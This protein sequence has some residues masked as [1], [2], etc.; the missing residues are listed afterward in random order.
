M[1]DQAPTKPLIGITGRQYPYGDV[2]GTPALLTDALVDAVLADYVRAVV[3]S[4]GLP[5]HIPVDVDR[6]EIV[7][8][9][10]GLVLTGGADIDPARYGAAA[11]AETGR[12]DPVRDD[13]ELELAA[14]ALDRG[15]PTLGVC[16]GMQVLN[17]AAGGTLHQHVETHACYRNPA[18]GLIHDIETEPETVLWRTYGPDHRVNSYHHQTVDRPG[19]SFRVTARA[20]DGEVEGM[21]H[22]T[23][24]IVAVQWH[25]EMLRERDPI[26]DWLVTAAAVTTAD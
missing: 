12:A 1:V 13:Y 10:D 4:G 26:F 17:V 24:P 16:R 15:L 22:I 25:P 18:P 2:A 3:L 5:V 6:T 23:A 9:L 21:E 11:A 7:A 8:A 19:G 20:A 14:A